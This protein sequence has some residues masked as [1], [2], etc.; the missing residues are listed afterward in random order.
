MCLRNR[1]LTNARRLRVADLVEFYR[2]SLEN[3]FGLTGASLHD[4]LAVAVFIEP[5]LFEL[6]P[7]HVE[8]ELHGA[9]T[10]GMTVCDNRHATRT[11]ADIGGSNPAKRGKEPNCEVAVAMDVPGFF[12]LLYKALAQY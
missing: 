6:K 7:M 9:V 11:G 4:P 2:A 12:D 5:E 1:G 8:I 10:R 3:V